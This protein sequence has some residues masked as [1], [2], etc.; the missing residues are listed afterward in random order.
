MAEWPEVG[1][2]AVYIARRDAAAW[3][4]QS[5]F[6]RTIDVGGLEHVHSP[7]NNM[8]EAVERIRMFFVINKT[9]SKWKLDMTQKVD[10]Q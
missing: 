8:N 6:V 9:Q 3:P 5:R 2:R 10:G 4:N 1:G 7:S